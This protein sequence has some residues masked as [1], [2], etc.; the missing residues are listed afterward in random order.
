MS[1]NKE[2]INRNRSRI[3]T[4]NKDFTIAFINILRMC[5][6]VK[7]RLSIIRRD[8]KDKGKRT[9]SAYQ[10]GNY[11]VRWKRWVGLRSG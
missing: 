4:G 11:N 5:G 2:S 8:M 1:H 6:K 7:E 9:N 10:A 3:D